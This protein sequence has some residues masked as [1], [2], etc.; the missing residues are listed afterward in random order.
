M[1]DT[2]AIIFTIVVIVAAVIVALY[3]IGRHLQKKQTEAAQVIEQNRQKVSAFIIDKK[4]AR[5][6][7]AN[8]PQAVYQQMPKRYRFLK[9]PLVKVKAGPQILTLICDEKAF[10]TLPL[11]K[12]VTL[13][14]AGG[15]ILSY[16]TGKKGEK[17]PVYE[18]KLTWREKLAMRA[19]KMQ[20]EANKP[21]KKKKK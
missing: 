15:Y 4:K 7:D 8:F 17:A 6:T 10:K 13:E 5:L 2:L 12:Q 11:K 18:K 1:P 21:V 16:T 19:Q 20:E 14:V 9:V 3:F